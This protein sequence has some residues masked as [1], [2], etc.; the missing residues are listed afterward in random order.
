MEIKDLI[1][2]EVIFKGNKCPILDTDIAM[3]GANILQLKTP[4]TDINKENIWIDIDECRI[5]VYFTERPA[6]HGVMVDAYDGYGKIEWRDAE[7]ITVPFRIDPKTS[8]LILTKDN[9]PIMTMKIFDM[10]LSKISLY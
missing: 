2:K 7:G 1:N 3:T 4:E 9:R 8:F 5:S 6:L 10:E